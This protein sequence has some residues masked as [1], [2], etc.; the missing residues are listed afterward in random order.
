MQFDSLQFAVFLPLVVLIYWRLRHGHQNILLLAAS[1]IFYGWWDVRFL[2]LIVLSS[3]ADYYLGLLIHRDHEKRPHHRMA[4]VFIVGVAFFGIGFDWSSVSLGGNLVPSIYVP[5]LLLA[6]GALIVALLLSRFYNKLAALPAEKLAKYAL[7]FSLC[8]NLGLLA[9]FKYFGFFVENLESGMRAFGLNPEPFRLHIILPVGISFYTFQTLSYTIDVYRKKLKPTDHFIDFALF[10]SFFPQLVAGPIERATN[11]LPQITQKRKFDFGQATDGV[12]LIL[13]GLFKKIAIAD[14]FSNFVNGVYGS[15]G[16]VNAV[17]VAAA[18]VAFAFQIYCDFSAYSD[19]ARG[20]AKL[21]GIHLMVNF[22]VPY[23][24]KN[25]QE[26]WRRWH[27]SL[28]TW[29]RDYLYISLGGNRKGTL[30]TYRNLAL[31]MILGGLWHGAAWNFVLW[32][33]YQGLLLCI[34]QAWRQFGFGKESTTP[35]YIDLFKMGVFFIFVCYGWMLFR[36][37]SFE[38]IVNFTAA[39]IF[40]WH[41]LDLISRPP[42]LSALAGLPILLI[43]DAVRYSKERWNINGALAM[44]VRAFFIAAMIACILLGL[45]NGRSEFI[46][47]QF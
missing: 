8:L 1:Y 23:F 28:S 38:Q 7:I 4:S 24:A 20:T 22:N 26:F 6:G 37:E 16:E 43:L 9:V 41:S 25:A 46:Y 39:L 13:F 27:I 29:L 36:A 35:I 21:L 34:F 47:F 40:D 10:V 33:I 15:T 32:G 19:I 14:G 11:L 45:N 44:P 12:Y 2:F 17:S 3:Y 42:R 31:T 5:G 18:T 30:F